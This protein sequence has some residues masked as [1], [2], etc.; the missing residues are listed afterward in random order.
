MSV[1]LCYNF[2]LLNDI[3]YKRRQAF[4]VRVQFYVSNDS[5]SNKFQHSSHLFFNRKNIKQKSHYEILSSVHGCVYYC[6]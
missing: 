4:N 3:Y 5:T 1:K 6:R 2:T